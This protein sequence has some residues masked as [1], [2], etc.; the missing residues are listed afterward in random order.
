LVVHMN[1]R[2]FDPA[3][4]RFLSADPYIDGPETT[5]G[6][7]RY[8]YVHGRVMSATDPTGFS[9]DNDKVIVSAINPNEVIENVTVTATR[10]V[11]ECLSCIDSNNPN[12]GPGG[13]G[14]GG[15]GGGGTQAKNPKSK[16][17]CEASVEKQPTEADV[18]QMMA[19]CNFNMSC[20]DDVARTARNIGMDVPVSLGQVM[21][22][23]LWNYNY[24]PRFLTG[25]GRLFDA[26]LSGV[27]AYVA[28]ST[29]NTNR[30][31]G[32]VSGQAL[33]AGMT[34]M[35]RGA[36][37]NGIKALHAVMGAYMGTLVEGSLIHKDA[38]HACPRQN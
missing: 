23:I 1:G 38:T 19:N 13:D 28:L 37:P 4:G 18:R 3:I 16:N 2:V 32:A 8:A 5:Q 7:N 15:R 30:A 27:D 25:G 31:A 22:D 12:G 11:F 26:G 6:W 34:A 21:R 17:P 9:E 20:V 33:E 10:I 29:G 14:S 36:A 35:Y 24:F